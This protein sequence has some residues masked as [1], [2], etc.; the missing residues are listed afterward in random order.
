MTDD[1]DMALVA[2]LKAAEADPSISTELLRKSYTIERRHQFDRDD[3][4]ELSM[5]ALKSLLEAIV[6]QEISA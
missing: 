6:D 3:T 5:Q 1:N 2:L 4:R